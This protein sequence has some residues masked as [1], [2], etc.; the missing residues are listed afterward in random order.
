[1]NLSKYISALEAIYLEHGDLEVE[2]WGAGGVRVLAQMP[3][4]THRMI[5][6]G[7]ESKPRFCDVYDAKRDP[8]RKGEKVVKV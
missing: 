8:A 2:T 3:A 4:V 5:L 1:M 7:R 6:Q